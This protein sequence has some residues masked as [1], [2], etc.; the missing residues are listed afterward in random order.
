VG[1][2]PV[3][4]DVVPDEVED[5]VLDVDLQ[6]GEVTPPDNGF[7]AGPYGF[8]PFDTAGPF[9]VPTLDGQVD[10][11]W[12]WSGGDDSYVFMFYHPDYEYATGLWGSSVKD[13]LKASPTN[14]HYFFLSYTNTPMADVEAL[15]VR[16][17][18]AISEL[19]MEALWEGR[20]HFVTVMPV[21]LVNWLGEFVKSK[22]YF[23]FAID[24]FQRVREVGLLA[25]V[26]GNGVAEMKYLA[27]EAIYFNFEWERE[28]KLA[29][30][31]SV[32]VVSLFEALELANDG[33]V[34]VVL[35][36]AEEMEQY[37]TLEFDLT[38][39]CKEKSDDNC[40]E[41]DYLA[42][43]YLCSKEEPDKC[44]VEIGRWITAYHRGG[45][46]VTDASAM[47]ALLKD[48]GTRRFRLNVSW[49]TYVTSLS[50]RL[51]NG[52]KGARP[53]AWHPLWTGGAF[54][55]TYNPSKEP[56]SIVIPATAKRVE[57]YALITG[58]GFGADT[59][60]C[61][62]FCNHTHHFFVNEVEY[63]KTHP[64]A[65]VGVGCQVMVKEGVVPNQF[66]TWPFGRSGW[67]PGWDVKPF[68]ADVTGAAKKGE[69]NLLTYKALY[70][71]KDYDPKP[72][73]GGDGFAARLDV[74]TYLVV[75]E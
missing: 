17:D 2:V 75:W 69:E 33:F 5:L 70:F 57:L 48:G 71:G 37:D 53:V 46:W 66:G 10:F 60:N 27:Q 50:F 58:H 64:M 23:A 68:V 24:R 14:V 4:A 30:V 16:F 26:V 59:A 51:S 1:D 43:L 9:K 3:L 34:D 74:T 47:L 7:S 35:P 12:I 44:D 32:K 39:G 21:T 22:G 18:E 6:D 52:G 72:V 31:Q 38:L 62:E 19:G 40:G 49:Q 13:L 56:K 29:S 36:S 28:Q 73:E 55:L 42:N 61:A 15:K 45:R 20:L 54:D 63:E 8:A 25:N 11:Q 65:G 67:C 41:W